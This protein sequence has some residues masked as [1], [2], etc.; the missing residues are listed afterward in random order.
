MAGDL[1]NRLRREAITQPRRSDDNFHFRARAGR[2]REHV[3]P[4]PLHPWRIRIV[5]EKPEEARLY[6][7]L[8]QSFG[9]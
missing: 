6:G 4:P 2:H 3:N 7:A 1:A 5:V 8:D 9:V